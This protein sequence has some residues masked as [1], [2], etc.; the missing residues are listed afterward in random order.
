MVRSTAQGSS[1]R[2]GC[3]LN[4][5]DLLEPASLDYAL[6]GHRRV[7]TAATARAQLTTTASTRSNWSA[8][9]NLINACGRRR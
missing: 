8:K 3:E 6:E 7:T 1:C 5:G 9:L 4:R 2:N